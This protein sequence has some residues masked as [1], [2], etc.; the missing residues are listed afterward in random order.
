MT[1]SHC[2][3]YLQ[4]LHITPTHQNSPS[5]SIVS[6]KLLRSALLT[7]FHSSELEGKTKTNNNKKDVVNE[8]KYSHLKE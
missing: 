7:F 5:F 4:I 1:I 8:S 3:H 6:P 2:S